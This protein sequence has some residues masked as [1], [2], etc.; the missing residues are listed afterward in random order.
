VYVGYYKNCFYP[1]VDEE[2]DH[3][4]G[5]SLLLIYYAFVGYDH[6]LALYLNSKCVWGFK[7]FASA[8]LFFNLVL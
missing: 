8:T 7:L 6:E 2:W 3:G 4:R 1:A 5:H